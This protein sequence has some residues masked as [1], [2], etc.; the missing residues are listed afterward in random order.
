MKGYFFCFY[1][2]YQS[3]GICLFMFQYGEDEDEHTF[4]LELSW[5]DNYPNDLPKINLELFYNQH[6]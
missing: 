1:A 5:G 2:K 6:L 3:Y 4:L